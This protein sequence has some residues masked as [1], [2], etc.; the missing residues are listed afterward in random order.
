MTSGVG[1]SFISFL[2]LAVVM[3]AISLSFAIPIGISASHREMNAI[4]W[5]V[6]A[7]FTWVVGLVLFLLNIQPIITDVNCPSCGNR[8]PK[9]HVF[10]PFCGYRD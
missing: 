2:F 8:I 6:I 9:E 3:I 7:F 4:G 10:C 1:V 5:A